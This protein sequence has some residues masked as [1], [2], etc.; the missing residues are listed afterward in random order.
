MQAIVA[1]LMG[2]AAGIAVAD[3]WPSFANDIGGSQYSP[4]SQLNPSNVA[5]LEQ[6]WVHRS[7]DFLDTGARGTSFQV[8][9][10]HANGLLYYCTPMNRVFALDPVSG[11]EVWVFDPHGPGT[12]GK[13]VTDEARAPG[14]CRGVAYW[15]GSEAG[16]STKPCERRVFKSDRFGHVYAID[17]DTG[18][19]CADFGAAKGHPGYV[20]QFDYEGYG[21]GHRGASSPPLVIGDVL[22]AAS[23]S[24]DGLTNAADGVVR[25]FDVQSGELLWTF[26]PI[27]EDLRDKTGAANVWATMSGDAE[28]G[29]V[30]LPTTSPSTDYYGGERL[31]DLPLSDAV[32]ALN[33]ATGEVVW[34]FQTVRHDLFD[35]DLPGH[36]LLVN[37]EKDGERRD[38]AIQQTKMGYLY[39]FDRLTGEPVFPIEEMPVPASDLPGEVAA[40]SQPISPGIAAFSGQVLR[41]EE[42]FG[43]TPFDRA[44]CQNRFDELRYEGQYTP[45]SAQGSILFPSALGGGNWGGAA[46][47][48]ERNLLIIKAENLATRLKL[49]P[50]EEDSAPVDY[51]TRSLQGT[52]YRTEGEV[53]LS[54]LG[55]P[56]TPPPWGTLAAID[57]DS[58]ALRWQI[59]LGQ[60]KRFG[61]TVPASFGWGSPNIGGPI[62]TAGGLIFVGA[63]FDEK[64]RALDVDT[65]EELWQTKLPITATAMPMT[66]EGEDGRQ[67][68][69]IA[70]GGTARVG[71]GAADYIIA[72]ALPE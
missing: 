47:D 10:I 25:G 38:V 59:P 63:T 29:L 66:Y 67:Y 27:P 6:A 65:G 8:T 33:A 1:T 62:L 18:T 23:G 52:P 5:G 40:A 61:M 32:V 7:G 37:I 36:A 2:V 50:K 4:L 9:P 17:A 60:V 31:F 22:V 3:D 68:V 42:L 28:N 26:N 58:G 70:A 45:P 54:P 49:L 24:N 56:C 34:S 64:F 71:T 16:D 30:F 12:D 20:S 13:P 41:R 44:W 53:F 46:F 11:K 57:M 55:I 15:A 14:T 69:V 21:E 43:V 72:F 48:Q 19:A 51:L 35:Y 39:V